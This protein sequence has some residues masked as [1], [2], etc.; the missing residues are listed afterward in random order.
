MLKNPGRGTD[1]MEKLDIIILVS[2]ISYLLIAIFGV[3]IGGVLDPTR[4][5]SHDDSGLLGFLGGMF[6]PIS[7]V[8]LIIW[9]AVVIIIKLS[10]IRK[11]APFFFKWLSSPI[12]MPIYYIIE[13]G[14]YIGRKLKSMGY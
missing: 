13:F 2:V 9:L 10:I 4:Y 11:Y 14:K 5:D 6:W 7:L 8:I 1:K 12:W 3:S